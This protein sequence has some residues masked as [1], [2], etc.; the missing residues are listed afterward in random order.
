[1]DLFFFLAFI[2]LKTTLLP[3]LQFSISESICVGYPVYPPCLL[4]FV[5]YFPSLFLCATFVM[6]PAVLSP[7]SP[8]FSWANP[9]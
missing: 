5:S 1:M 2:F 6:N 8:M 3:F 7:K 4:T 9:V